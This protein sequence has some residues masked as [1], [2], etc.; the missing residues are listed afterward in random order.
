MTTFTINTPNGAET[1][2]AESKQVDDS[3]TLGFHDAAGHMV[4]SYVAGEWT[5]DEAASKDGEKAP[6][7]A[8]PAA[9]A[10]EAVDRTVTLSKTESV[11]SS[12]FAGEPHAQPS[13]DHA[14]EDPK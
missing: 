2:E 9:P 4:K 12:A 13:T 14:A 1:I 3:G 7:E 5:P 6:W 8:A 11:Q 10:S